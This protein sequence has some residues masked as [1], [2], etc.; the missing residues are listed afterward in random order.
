MKKIVIALL[1]MTTLACVSSGG[2]VS[3]PKATRATTHTVE[4]IVKSTVSEYD[5]TYNN[6]QG[7]TEQKDL[8]IRDWTLSM[9]VEPG[10]FAYISA[11]IG[12]SG[13]ISCQ[14][15]QDGKVIEEATSDGRYVIA[16][17]S[18]SIP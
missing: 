14:I 17:C 6:A 7:N 18:A 8:R 3:T 12:G 15:K 16:T 2:S 10:F 11:Q 9:T 1:I 5:I 13:T 4:Y